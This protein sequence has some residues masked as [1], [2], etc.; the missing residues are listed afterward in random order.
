MNGSTVSKPLHRKLRHPPKTVA[1][2][3]RTDGPFVMAHLTGKHPQCGNID[4]WV[5][6]LKHDARFCSARGK[7]ARN[8]TA[9]D[10]AARAYWPTHAPRAISK[11]S[12]TLG[13]LRTRRPSHDRAK[14]TTHAGLVQNGRARFAGALRYRTL[15][16]SNGLIHLCQSHALGLYGDAVNL[17]RMGNPRRLPRISGA[18][19]CI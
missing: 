19:K 10:E 3:V 15:S 5:K 11:P 16:S 4:T 8:A 14:S 12:V 1:R 7:K 9:Y 6:S 13:L 17:G 18:R 2:A